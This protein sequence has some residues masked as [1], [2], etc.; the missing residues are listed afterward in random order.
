VSK[1]IT[2]SASPVLSLVLFSQARH[3]G[4][5]PTT[6]GCACIEGDNEDGHAEEDEGRTPRDGVSESGRT[7]M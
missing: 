2:V 1:L 5:V 7:E 3:E 6:E 4:C